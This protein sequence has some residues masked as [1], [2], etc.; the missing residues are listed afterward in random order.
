MLKLVF[1]LENFIWACLLFAATLVVTDCVKTTAKYT[2][3]F[4]GQKIT[5]TERMSWLDYS[6][7]RTEK[8]FISYE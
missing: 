1:C 4:C 8:G 6:L 2:K 7:K 3:E 5:L